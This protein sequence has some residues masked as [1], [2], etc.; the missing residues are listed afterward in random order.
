M[1]LTLDIYTENLHCCRKS[2]Q[3]QSNTASKQHCEY[4]YQLSFLMTVRQLGTQ[5][6]SQT[7]NYS[8]SKPLLPSEW[9]PLMPDVELSVHDVKVEE[10]KHEGLDRMPAY[11]HFEG[12]Q[13]IHSKAEILLENCFESTSEPRG[14]GLI[15][16]FYFI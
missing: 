15:S 16:K 2:G 6:H 5:T 13:G 1:A 11:Q 3:C 10:N 4:G 9:R 14:V 7:S 12:C 8:M